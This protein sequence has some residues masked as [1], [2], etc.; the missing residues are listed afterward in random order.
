MKRHGPASFHEVGADY[1]ARLAE[2]HPSARR[3]TDKLLG[4]FTRLGFIA[5]ALPGAR[6]IH[7]RRDPLDCCLSIHSRHF[8]EGH[9]YASDLGELGRYYRA[10]SE[11]MAHWR[12]ALP[13]GMMIELNYEQVVDD[14]AGQAGTLLDFLGLPWHDRCLDFHKTERMIRTAS[15]SQVRRPLT[16]E[17]IGRWHPYGPHVGPLIDALGPSADR[18]YKS[19]A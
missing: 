2:I 17:G 5:S 8:L 7:M 3:V 13:A 18:D 14:L 16:R 4:N 1:L 6:I 10:Y 15:Q 11:L 19:G 9:P 12:A